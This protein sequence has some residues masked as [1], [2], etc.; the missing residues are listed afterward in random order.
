MN[1]WKT[2][3]NR[4]LVRR[5]LS[6]G[7][8]VLPVFSSVILPAA[9]V[10]A[11][12]LAQRTA[13]T[14]LTAQNRAIPAPLR[15]AFT[16]LNRGQ[17]TQAIAQF[18]R[19][20][21]TNPQSL[22]AQL[23][24]AIA[25]RRAGR[26]ADSFRAYQR[27]LEIDP[28]N[29]LALNTLGLFGEFR[30]EW[31]EQGIAALTTLLNLEPGNNEA[32]AQRAKLYFFRGQFAE[33]VADYTIV[34]RN[35]PSPDALSNAAQVFTYS[36]D[37]Q[38]GLALFERYRQTGK[39]IRG[40]AAV[41]YALALRETG[42]LP[43]AIQVLEAELARSRQLDNTAIQV[44][45]ALAAAYAEDQQLA[46]AQTILAPLRN[47]ADAQLPLARAL[48]ILGRYN[49]QFAAEAATIYRQVLL[50][51]QNPA[52]SLV[53]EVADVLSGVPQ[54]RQF[55]LQLYQQLYQQQPNDQSLL[56]QQ[57]ILASQLGQISRANLRQQLQQAFP[58]LP[59]DPVQLRL[60]AQ[61]LLSLDPPDPGL[62]PLYQALLTA[63]VNQPFLN[64]R[65]AQMR[66]LQGDLAGARAA[67]AAYAATPLGNRDQGA[68]LLALAEIDRREGN[69]EG[70]AQ[71][72]QTI[73]TSGI[74]DEGVLNGALQGLASIRQAQ[75]RVGEA[76]ALYDQLIARDPSNLNVQLGRAALAYQAGVI[77]EAEA[78]ALLDRFLQTQPSA[79]LPGEVVALAGAL[80]P[81]PQREPLYVALLTADPNA[82]AIQLRLAQ[83]IAARNPAQAEALVN[84]LIARD[85]TNLGAYFV[86]GQVAQ[87]LGNLSLASSAY[88]AILQQQPSNTDALSALG[89]VRFQQRRYDTA[90]RLY[91]QVLSLNP[92][93]ANARTSL[94]ALQA[95]QGRPLD[96][97]QQLEQLQLFQLQSG[98]ANPNLTEQMQRIQE[99][100]LQRRGIQPPWERF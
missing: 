96:A 84:Q 68:I 53:R 30:P 1:G 52:P 78:S 28:N 65:I 61:A 82:L 72:Y 43:Q 79:P 64:Y 38:G 32:R 46:R 98:V 60:I 9:Q 8:V 25:Y 27:V 4:I 86:Q 100:F 90:A 63:G 76:I 87:Q 73:L 14:D 41:A 24:L 44:R 59:S 40:D 51:T 75:G 70:S 21:R 17:V 49:D 26:D 80:P 85:P 92:Q 42:N 15:E 62:L 77:S 95:A 81:S 55:A 88:E 34:L 89:G 50:N 58:V 19:F 11:Q 16:L 45:A 18:E 74:R 57:L 48:S 13:P 99:G 71:R 7:F 5:S 37:F 93:D 39:P 23:G 10:M 35:N 6:L 56:V 12:T 91:N 22:E 66:I 69:L 47:R 94:I 20:L 83:V 29:R 2:Q 33:S 67:L 36:G 97:L 54:E 3:M 31:Q